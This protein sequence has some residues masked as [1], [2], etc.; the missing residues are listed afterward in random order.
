MPLGAKGELNEVGAC[1]LDLARGQKGGSSWSHRDSHWLSRHRFGLSL[2][3]AVAGSTERPSM[4][5]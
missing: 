3:V 1:R 5:D 4:G 2:V